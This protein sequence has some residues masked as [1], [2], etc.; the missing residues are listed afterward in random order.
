L[1]QK[2]SLR[3]IEVKPGRAENKKAR[4]IAARMGE[5]LFFG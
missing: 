3:A 2:Q 1:L 4:N 5:R